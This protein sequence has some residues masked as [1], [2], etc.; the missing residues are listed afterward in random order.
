VTRRILAAR[1]L[2]AENAEDNLRDL[3][4]RFALGKRPAGR[5]RSRGRAATNGCDEKGEDPRKTLKDTETSQTGGKEGDGSA[6]YAK[7][8]ERHEG[9]FLMV[10]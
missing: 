1:A 8:R 4:W 9:A 7:G 10:S 5:R 6:K 3:L 2:K